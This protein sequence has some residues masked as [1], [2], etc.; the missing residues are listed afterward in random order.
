MELK[1]NEKG[2]EKTVY[3]KPLI[4]CDSVEKRGNSVA[5]SDIN[6]SNLING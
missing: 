2:I 6:E 5:V 4:T 3:Q 1:L